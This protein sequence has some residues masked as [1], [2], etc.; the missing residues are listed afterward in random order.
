[1][2][3]GGTL[4][5]VSNV[6]AL[7]MSNDGR[8]AVLGAIATLAP[9]N[10]LVILDA[11]KSGAKGPSRV[12]LAKA[13]T[14]AKGYVREFQS[15]KA[16][17]LTG[18]IQREAADRG[19]AIEPS[20]ANELANRVGGFVLQNDAE[21]PFQTRTASSELDKLALY[22]GSA[23]ITAADVRA[24]VAEAIPGTVWG[25]V[26]AVAERKAGQAV[27]L[28]ED[29]IETTPEPVL[30]VMLHR[31]VR[32]L[33][34]IADLVGSGQSLPAVGKALGIK[35]EFRVRTLSGQARNWTVAELTDAL[36][37]LL[38]LDAM[39]KHAPG[40]NADDAQRRLAFTL[41][42]MDHVARRERRSA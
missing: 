31:R 9:G 34:E 8:D 37:G 21:R 18:W 30:L 3:G 16:N 13:V 22:R 24:L 6:G 38:E 40:S 17:S 10:A 1:M 11:T 15:P 12:A 29:L 41:W 19:I 5:V 14:E 26:D 25:F 28:L 4:A 27:G 42:V 32:E 2:F 35:S 23:P 20:A 7:M 33:L 36:D 39:V